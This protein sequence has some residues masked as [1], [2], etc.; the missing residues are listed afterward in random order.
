MK[1]LNHLD[2]LKIVKRS[3]SQIICVCPVCGDDSLKIALG[4]KR[5][6][7]KCW[8]TGCSSEDIK[9]ALGIKSALSPTHTF[10][11][12]KNP[13]VIPTISSVNFTGTKFCGLESHLSIPVKTKY[14]LSIQRDEMVK[15]HR[16]IYPYSD[17]QRLLR[18]DIEGSNFKEK[19][20]CIQ[21]RDQ[22]GQWVNGVA[23]NAS[24]LWP[25]YTG[26]STPRSD[27]DTTVFVEGEKTAEYL[28]DR[29]GIFSAT[30]S[31]ITFNSSFQNISLALRLFF[32]KY[33]FITNV[34]YIPDSD[35][36]GKVK[37]DKLE[38][39]MWANQRGY[40]IKPL[41]SFIPKSVLL[42]Q[43]LQKGLD[44]ADFDPEQFNLFTLLC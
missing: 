36:A 23:S 8:T 21:T 7:Y 26:L 25:V 15:I 12:P 43:A 29:L 4:R 14:E 16:R 34:I 18:W 35:D 28:K 5:G 13:E 40:L 39:P 2:S 24:T 30:L 44:I 42:T 11:K 3:S 22:F 20:P 41:E 1:I 27:G 17:D 37:A 32:E 38:A 31:A 9:K 10:T 33:P 19:R 6:A